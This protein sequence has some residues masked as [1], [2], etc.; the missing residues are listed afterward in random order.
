MAKANPRMPIPGREDEGII[1]TTPAVPAIPTP[2][3]LPTTNYVPVTPS[4]ATVV[5]EPQNV[6]VERALAAMSAG[7]LP[8]DA[9][10][11]ESVVPLINQDTGVHATS[12]GVIALTDNAKGVVIGELTSSAIAELG[13]IYTFPGEFVRRL[14]PG[15]Q[16][17][18]IQEM[19]R[20]QPSISISAICQGEGSNRKVLHT[21][22]AH[23]EVTP[24]RDIANKFYYE[25]ILQAGQMEL[26][27]YTL[28]ESGMT[29]VVMEVIEGVPVENIG[30]LRRGLRLRYVPGKSIEIN[31]YSTL[32]PHGS[33]IGYPIISRGSKFLWFSKDNARTEVQVA[34]IS[35]GIEETLVDYLD[36]HTGLCAVVG[37]AFEGNAAAVLNDICRSVDIP[38]RVAKGAINDYL[39][40]V[41][42]TYWHLL[43]ALMSYITSGGG[44]KPYERIRFQ[45]YFGKWLTDVV[46]TQFK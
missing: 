24:A 34:W 23:R 37:Q 13:L 25:A 2:Q 42:L 16:A 8:W 6:R 11:E 31:Q 20:A 14:S 22:F 12:T 38:V 43:R 10:T 9:A 40:D 44:L 28:D 7:P 4:E 21:V 46:P 45:T 15:S 26:T 35:S 5:I 29:I 19:M 30:M 3:V 33:T 27:E 18:V 1:P 17:N 32:K 39:Q 36:V 41:G